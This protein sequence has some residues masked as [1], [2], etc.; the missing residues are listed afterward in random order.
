MATPALTAAQEQ[1]FAQAAV[2]LA[3]IMAQPDSPYRRLPR[4]GFKRGIDFYTSRGLLT[5]LANALQAYHAK[6]GVFPNLIEPKGY[7]ETILRFKFFGELKVPEAGDKLATARF[8]PEPWRDRI[9]CP[10][11]VW[12]SPA[13]ALPANDRIPPGLYYLKSNHG[14]GMFRKIRYPLAEAERAELQ[15]L[16]KGWLTRDYGVQDGEWWYAAFPRRILL[17][18][19]VCGDAP[20]VSWNIHVLGGRIGLVELFDKNVQPL[21][22]TWLDAR[23]QPMAVQM[24]GVERIAAPRMPADPDGLLAA[25]LA[26]AAPFP[27]ARVDFFI[28]ADGA[29]YLGELTFSPSNAMGRRP[30]DIERRLGDMLTPGSRHAGGIRD[31]AEDQ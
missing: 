15:A 4:P 28:G 20:P 8:I 11:V 9:R 18:R 24:D 21:Q 23:L 22:V 6:F 25:A 27:F 13:P 2:Q 7:N 10:T 29:A 17:E 5:A 14:S 16:C 12:H 3:G 19:D 26:I 31:A 30:A 1:A